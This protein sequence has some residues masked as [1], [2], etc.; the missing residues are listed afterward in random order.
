MCVRRER[1]RGFAQPG[2][3][4]REVVRR[5]CR[6]VARA[7][8]QRRHVQGDHVETVEEI[9]PEA[10]LPDVMLEGAVRCGD[11]PYV[12]MANGR[13]AD[14]PH[15][16]AVEKPQHPDLDRWRHVANL[17]Q[18]QDAA[19]RL[20]DESRLVRHRARERSTAVPEQLALGE[21]VGERPAVHRDELRTAATASLE[22]LAGDHFLAGPGFSGDQHGAVRVGHPID[23]R[24]ERTCAGVDGDAFAVSTSGREVATSPR[25]D[26]GRLLGVPH[27]MDQRIGVGLVSQHDGHLMPPR[28]PHFGRHQ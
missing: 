22:E 11:D 17:I 21:R 18:E 2:R 25:E 26:V 13:V 10:P 15:L 9:L 6:N 23:A 16:T 1:P 3:A 19:I 8:A 5:E 24:Q 28:L 7:L 4:A 14:A 27:E 20:L 12:N